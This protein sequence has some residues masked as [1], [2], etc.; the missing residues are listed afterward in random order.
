MARK[1][2]DKDADQGQRLSVHPS[3][4]PDKLPPKSCLRGMRQK[5]SLSSCTKDEKSAFAD[6]LYELSRST[7]AQL[8]QMPKK[9]RGWE[10]I[11]RSAIKGDKVPSSLTEDVNIIAFRCVGKAPMVGYRSRDGVFNILWIDRD[12]TLYDHG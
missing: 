4:D 10:I 11:Q 6:R 1:L 9:G 3:E 12:F 2:K 8:R 7:W 5:Y